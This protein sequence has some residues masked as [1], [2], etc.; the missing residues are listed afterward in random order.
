VKRRR[1]AA[2]GGG[3]GGVNNKGIGEGAEGSGHGVGGVD[4]RREKVG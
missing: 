4:V 1:G 2:L 3:G